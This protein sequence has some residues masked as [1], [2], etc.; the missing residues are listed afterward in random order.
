MVGENLANTLKSS[1][2][3][4]NPLCE[5]YRIPVGFS[6]RLCL[7][8]ACLTWGGRDKEEEHYSTEDEFAAWTPRGFGRYVSPSGWTL[9]NRARCSQHIETWRSNAINL[10]RMFAA[11]Y[12]ADWLQERVDAVEYLG[13]STWEFLTSSL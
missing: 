7:S 11:I 9:E 13:K 8:A 2:D 3:R 4:L 12:G 5:N 1:N 6:N 10:S